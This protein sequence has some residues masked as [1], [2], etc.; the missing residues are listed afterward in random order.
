MPQG[1]QTGPQGQGPLTGRGLGI[2]R[3]M[4]RGFNR[5]AGRGFGRGFN[6]RAGFAGLNGVNQQPVELNKEQE[7][8]VLEAELAE[9]EAEKNQIEKELK[10]LKN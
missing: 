1:D 4:R 10:G 8:K 2:C 5:G 7:K 9:L 6:Q 3:G